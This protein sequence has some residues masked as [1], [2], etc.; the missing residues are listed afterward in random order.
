MI[1]TLFYNAA[2]PFHNT[3]YMPSK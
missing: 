2:L 3:Q 1:L